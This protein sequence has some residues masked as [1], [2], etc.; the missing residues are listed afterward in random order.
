LS[1]QDG[2]TIEA[3]VNPS[4]TKQN[5]YIVN[6]AS[7]GIGDYAYGLKLESGYTCYSEVGGIIADPAGHLYFAYGGSVPNNSWTH[8]AMT[9][10]VGDSHIRLYK[11]GVE[12]TYRYGAANAATDTIPAETHIR[13]NTAPLNMGVIP[14]S[15]WQF[16]N[17]IMDEVRILSYALT[18]GEIA[19]DCG[20][21]YAPSGYLTSVLVTPPDQEGWVT[22]EAASGLPAGT[23]ITY[24]ILDE[25]DNTLLPDVVSGEDISSLGSTPIRL[26]AD[27]STANPAMT[28][29]LLSWSLTS[30]TPTAVN[31]SAFFARQYPGRV[32]LAWETSS[33][34][35]LVGFNLYRS[36]AS[37]GDKLKMNQALIPGKSAGSL[38]G[39]LYDY[40]DREVEQG[41]IYDYWIELVMQNG[42]Q[43]F[44][45]VRAS[46]SYRICLPVLG[47]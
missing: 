17:G 26:R 18:P 46:I 39:N 43:E 40:Q 12:V 3:W 14:A 1:P 45:P 9:Y 5:N 28:P 7:N 24:S 44:G 15:T 37:A 29:L 33:E 20:T 19:V 30:A 13:T 22:F 35:E 4:I 27:L 41:K 47:R 8:I 11:N 25:A 23:D 38:T 36:E 6:K 2:I 31:L 21:S 16:F 34:V 42:S 10:Q 32:E